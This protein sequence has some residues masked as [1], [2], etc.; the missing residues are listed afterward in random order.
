MKMIDKY[1]SMGILSENA[2]FEYMLASLKDT[3]RTY[4]FF[5]AWEKVLGNVS[6]IEVSLN[7]M[8]S[9]IGKDDISKRLKEL[10]KEY[11][12]IVSVIPILIAVRGLNIKV[13]E[14]GGDIEYS[15][16]KRTS[17]SDDE[18]NKIV[19]FA[20]ECG[21]LKILSDK[22]VK[23]LVDYCIG[24]EVGL[25]TNARKN[26]SGTAME[27]LTEFYV[28]AISDKYGYKYLTQATATRIKTEFNKDVP[29]DKADRHFDFAIN[30]KEKIYLVEVNYYGGGGSKLK[31]VAG[32]FKS[33]FELM[34]RIDGV[35]FIWITDGLGWH[36]ARRPLLE[37]F[38]ATD[39]VMNIK[40]IENG[41]LEEILTKG[42]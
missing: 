8:N 27:S 9:L 41:L 36:T 5:V 23:N 2:A 37:T 15:F 30:T 12:Q 24:V 19:F 31:S 26:R 4:D 34:N 20:E 14:V 22:N 25:D 38:N 11:P 3:I 29:T 33:L 32:E 39:Y 13:V 21:L 16:A 10:I 1:K 35:G 40:M 18:I 42:L 7:I 6:Q 17:Y 28:K